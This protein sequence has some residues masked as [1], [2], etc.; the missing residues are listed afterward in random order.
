[1]VN[2]IINSTIGLAVKAIVKEP[3]TYFN[4]AIMAAGTLT[5]LES[6]TKIGLYC[7]SIVAST[8][9][10]VKYLYEIK[11]IKDGKKTNNR[12]NKSSD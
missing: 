4:G 5:T 11:Q 7:A 2:L 9:V 10:S 1:M 12:K 3:L 6:S 8:L